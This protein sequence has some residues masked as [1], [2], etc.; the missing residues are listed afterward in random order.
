MAFCHATPELHGVIKNEKY[1]VWEYT[2]LSPFVNQTKAQEC[3][4]AKVPIFD[5]ATV[6][7]AYWFTLQSRYVYPSKTLGIQLGPLGSQ[8]DCPISKS[9]T[10]MPYIFSRLPAI[11]G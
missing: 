10:I 5:G 9:L 1:I 2:T 8:A 7:I 11:L 6:I 4:E 3:V